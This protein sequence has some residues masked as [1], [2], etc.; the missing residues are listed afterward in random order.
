MEGR[1]TWICET[2]RVSGRVQRSPKPT[3]EIQALE[4]TPA[5]P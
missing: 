4:F 1:F 2:G 5:Q 3:V